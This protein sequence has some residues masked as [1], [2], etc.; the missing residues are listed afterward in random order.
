[1]MQI[2]RVCGGLGN[3]MFQYAFSKALEAKSSSPVKLDLSIY[4]SG[5]TMQG[6]IDLVHNGFELSKVFNIKAQSATEEEIKSLAVI[7]NGFIQRLR[8]KYFTPKT[9]FIDKDFI[10][11]PELLEPSNRYYDGYWQTEKYFIDI[12][13]TLY[14]D[15]TFKQELSARSKALLENL[16]NAPLSMHIRR[17]DYTAKDYYNVCTLEYYKKALKEAYNHITPSEI[18]IFSNC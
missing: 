9:H 12:K 8:R 10:Y 2:V 11:Q 4:Q 6:N 18:I 15:F 13:D 3:Q 16:G 14:K 7:P 1:M 5:K 17:G